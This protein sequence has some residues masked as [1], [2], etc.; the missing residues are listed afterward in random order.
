MERKK[1]T[2]TVHTLLV[3]AA[4]NCGRGCQTRN[5]SFDFTDQVHLRPAYTIATSTCSLMSTF[6]KD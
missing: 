2:E 4:R 5:A 6:S 1:G 3:A